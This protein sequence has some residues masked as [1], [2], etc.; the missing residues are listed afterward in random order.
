[1]TRFRLICTASVGAALAVAVASAGL[2]AAPASAVA[3]CTSV[4]TVTSNTICVLEDGKTLAYSVHGANG[5]GA[6][7]GRGAQVEGEYTNSSGAAQTL[8]LTVGTDGQDTGDS[9]GGGGY[10]AIALLAYDGTPIVIAG[11][12][13][14]YGLYGGSGG[15]AGGAAGS[16]AGAGGSGCCDDGSDGG[17]LNTAGAGGLSEG[18]PDEVGGAGGAAGVNGSDGLIYSGEDGGSGAGGGGFGASGGTVPSCTG[19]T[20]ASGGLPGGGQACY[21]GGGGGGWAGGG[22][23]GGGPYDNYGEGGG[24]GGGSSLVPSGATMSVGSSTASIRLSEV[25]PT[26]VPPS[27]GGGTSI[28]ATITI[29]LDANGATGSVPALSGNQGSWAALPGAE[30]LSRPGFE[31]TGWNSAPDGSGTAYAAGASI[32]LN[33]GNTLYAQ[34][35]AVEDASGGSAGGAD[36]QLD[37]I[38]V[39]LPAGASQLLS[40]GEPVAVTVVPNRKADPVALLVQS[41]GLTP[42]LNMRLEGRGDDSDPLGLTSKQVLILQSAPATRARVKVQPV[43][44]SSGDGFKATSP[45]KFY[46]LANTYLGTLTTNES[47]AYSGSLPIPAGITPGVYTLQASGFAPDGSVRSLSIGVQVRSAAT[48][49]ATA[50][51]SA[52]VY[53]AP[54]STDLSASAKATL[55][56]LAKRVGKRAVSSMVVGYVQPTSNTGND[57]TL[58]TARAKK[59]A[60]YLRSQGVKGSF[61]VRGDGRAKDAGATARRVQVTITYNKG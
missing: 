28:P 33:E 48:K 2:F 18:T 39:D 56:S 9:S 5:G 21:G 24:G 20:A 25:T 13:G 32:E 42:P 54:L 1:M 16:G 46:L 3:D 57:Q 61:T 26:P 58:S 55:T 60:A 17:D 50:K 12:G 27:G 41:Q 14:G 40:N 38:R 49:A 51:S 30:G 44:Q 52:R 35:R 43:A 59:V 45:V 19:P 15:N 31:F 4:G 47:G 37:P 10:S 11:G 34:W 23:G 53:F 6:D 29:G 8:Y 36:P 22:G 7:G